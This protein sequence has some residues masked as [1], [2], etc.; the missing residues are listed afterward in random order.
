MTIF[1]ELVKTNRSYRRFFEDK[2]IDLN[3]LEELI[4]LARHTA[5]GANLQP[6]KY[7]LSCEAEKNALIF[8]CLGWAGYL[9]HW[10]GPSEGE[11]PTGYVVVLGDT[12]IAKD[13][14]CDHGIASQTILLGAREK[15]LGGCM[16]ASVNRDKLKKL[17]NIDDKFQI[18]L[19][20]ALGVPKETV[21]I[22]PVKEDGGIKYYRDENEV[23][24]VPK[25]SLSDII[26]K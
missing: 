9:P 21:V 18:L 7:L 19:V 3:T 14:G 17:L 15:G 26:I 12:D 25:R 6:L 5:S 8:S 10:P 16:I 23:H 11:R 22:E 20:L 24:H 13:F 4:D 1:S 2:A